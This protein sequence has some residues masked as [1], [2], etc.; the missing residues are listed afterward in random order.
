MKPR[1]V[2]CHH[3]YFVGFFLIWRKSVAANKL[4]INHFTSSWCKIGLV[5]YSMQYLLR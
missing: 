4:T 3:L 5:V 2:N 1:K